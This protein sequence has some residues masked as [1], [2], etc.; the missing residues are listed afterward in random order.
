MHGDIKPANILFGKNGEAKVVDFGLASFIGQ[1]ETQSGEIWGTPY[2]IAPEKAKGKP[3]DFRSDIYSLG[4]TL[5]HVLTGCPP[6][7]GDTPLDVVL[8]RLNNPAP[9]I[10][11]YRP[12]LTEETAAMIARTLEVEPSMRHPSYLAL[13]ADMRAALEAANK[14]GRPGKNMKVRKK[15]RK[16]PLQPIQENQENSYRRRRGLAAILSGGL[17]FGGIQWKTGRRG[18]RAL[19]RQNA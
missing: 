16:P 14:G 11:E 8:A 10:L 15:V 1:K 9:N 18:K 5:F 3:A 19:N 13:L 2:Y 6:F 7:D 12:D 4:G 17:V